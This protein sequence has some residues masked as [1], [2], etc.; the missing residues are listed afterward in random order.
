MEVVETAVPEGVR[1]A[2]VRH[3]RNNNPADRS[4]A[5]RE[6]FKRSFL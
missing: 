5:P 2:G 1:G 3:L 4:E 6:I